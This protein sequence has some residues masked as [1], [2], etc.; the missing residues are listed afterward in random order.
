M[1][2]FEKQPGLLRMPGRFKDAEF[3]DKTH[4]DMRVIAEEFINNFE[5]YYQQ[6]LAP[7]FFGKPGI[8]KTYVAAVIAKTL[9]KQDI[10]VFWVEVVR[11]LNY[12]MELRDFRRADEYLALKKHI[13]ATPLVVFDDFTHLQSFE[14]T[15][16]LFFEVV[17]TRYACNLSTIFTANFALDAEG[18]K[19]SWQTVSHEFGSAIARRISLMSKGLL[20]SG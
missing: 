16:E 12:M 5:K 9:Y 15:R 19:V 2:R 17:N 11:M 8:G 7:T 18:N 4:K 6:G 1:I 10:P 14:R 20:F 13:T 3:D